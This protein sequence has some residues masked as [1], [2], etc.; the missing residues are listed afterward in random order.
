MMQCQCQAQWPVA[1]GRPVRLPH[2]RSEVRVSGPG[3]LSGSGLHCQYYILVALKALPLAPATL[4]I[5]WQYSL[6]LM[7]SGSGTRF[8][9]WH[10]HYWQWHWQTT[11]TVTVAVAVGRPRASLI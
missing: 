9:W 8:S 1:A 3:G 10:C 7:S 5:H 11:V 2:G 4:P 6:R